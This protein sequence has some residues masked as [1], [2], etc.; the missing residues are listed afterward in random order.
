MHPWCP[1]LQ[2]SP[3]VTAGEWVGG[4]GV[5]SWKRL[6]FLG[7]GNLHTCYVSSLNILS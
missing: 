2:V 5:G 4:C 3:P 7:L 6:E 1:Q